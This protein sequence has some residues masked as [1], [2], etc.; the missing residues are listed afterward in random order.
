MRAR[1]GESL[2]PAGDEAI[3]FAGQ[4]LKDDKNLSDYKIGRNCVIGF[5]FNGGVQVFIEVGEHTLG[6]HTI[7]S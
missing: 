4:E 3:L 5:D 7:S 6:G 1:G 2:G